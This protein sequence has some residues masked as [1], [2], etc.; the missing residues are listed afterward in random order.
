MRDALGIQNFL[1]AGDHV[2]LGPGVSLFQSSF[3]L[4]FGSITRRCCWDGESAVSW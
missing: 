3:L 1:H 4:H 2:H